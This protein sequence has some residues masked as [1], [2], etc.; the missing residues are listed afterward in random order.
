ME[1][2]LKNLLGEDTLALHMVEKTDKYKALIADK[3]KLVYKVRH[4]HTTPPFHPCT[5]ALR[6]VCVSALWHSPFLPA[7]LP[8]PPLIYVRVDYYRWRQPV[9]S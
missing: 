5:R 6:M 1:K 2:Y 4:H 8:S 9:R 3:D 7:S